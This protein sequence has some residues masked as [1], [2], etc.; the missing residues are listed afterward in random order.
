VDWTVELDAEARCVRVATHGVFDPA[1]P[2]RMIEDVISSPFFRPGMPTLFDH[3]ALDLSGVSYESIQ[4]AT[5]AHLRK[6]D[7]LGGGRVAILVGSASD[8][9]SARQYEMLIEGRA[10]FPVQCFLDPEAA[11]TWV[12]TSALVW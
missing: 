7:R 12:S 4:R 6:S 8:F 5:R 9:A 3:R 10:D 1:G 2:A 11:H